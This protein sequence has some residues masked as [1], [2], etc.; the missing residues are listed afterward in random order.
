MNTDNLPTISNPKT[1]PA[2]N[3]ICSVIDRVIQTGEPHAIHA[4]KY[5]A[6]NT[7]KNKLFS[8]C[9]CHPER[10]KI[11]IVA[12]EHAETI[13]I[14]L[15][16]RAGLDFTSSP[17]QSISTAYKHFTSQLSQS[18]DMELLSLLSLPANQ[19]LETIQT[20]TNTEIRKYFVLFLYLF[21]KKP[22]IIPSISNIDNIFSPFSNIENSE[23]AS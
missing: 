4:P 16:G 19:V 5:Y 2:F 10:R 1:L 17:Q 14:K 23:N 15:K 8:L 13:S 18:E 6:F 12:N 20:S 9:S 21:Y 3:L 11:I 7:F 22:W